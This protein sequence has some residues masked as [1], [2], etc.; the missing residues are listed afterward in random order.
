MSTPVSENSGSENSGSEHSRSNRSYFVPPKAGDKP[1]KVRIAPSPTGDP[2]IGTAYIAIFNALF[3][4]RYGGT[5]IIRIEDTD[6]SRYR[7]DAEAKLLQ[8]LKWL[9][10]EWQEGPDKSGSSSCGPYRQSERLATYRTHAD[11]LVQT[12]KAYPCFCTAERLAELRKTR[13][14]DK[15]TGYD[16]HCRTLDPE[17][18]QTRIKNGERHVIR[19]AVPH[20]GT[21]VIHDALRGPI[22]FENELVDDQVLLKSDGF[23]TYHL[24]VVVDDHL[25]GIS[26]VI[27]GE[28]WIT[29]TPKHVLLYNAFG[30]E[31]PVH[32]H[33]PLL[34]N[35]DKSKISKRKNPTNIL[36]YKKRGIL[37]EALV[38]F[39][40]LIGYHPEGDNEKFSLSDLADSF[41]PSRIHLGGPVFD[42]KKLTWLNGMYLRDLTPQDYLARLRGEQFSD[43]YLLDVIQLM[44]ERVETLD[45]FV[46]KSGF[47]FSGELTIDMSEIVPKKST[48]QTTADALE[49]MLDG[50]ENDTTWSAASIHTAMEVVMEQHQL[51]PKDLLMPTRIAVTGRKDS[52]P[53]AETLQVLGKDIVRKRIRDAVA[54]LRGVP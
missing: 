42:L 53:L 6:R 33:L 54:L 15:E 48:P 23:P 10:L 22:S 52:P 25:M 2:H 3:A 51:K 44:R 45:E 21:T 41:D 43:E 8:S 46:P 4:K 29:S 26:H 47:F 39:L 28:E 31:V 27:R 19:L 18:S 11:L 37:P 7:S 5:F 40:A 16:G 24:A 1:V 35:D 12:G 50:L 32:M 36:Y 17:Q 14:G 38:N 34:R 30:W 49:K 13:Q 20:S 9:G